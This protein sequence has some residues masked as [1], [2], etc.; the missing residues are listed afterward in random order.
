MDREKF[1]QLFN[2]VKNKSVSLQS[3][4]DTESDES[5]TLTDAIKNADSKVVGEGASKQCSYFGDKQQFAMLKYKKTVVKKAQGQFEKTDIIMFNDWLISKGINTPKL[6][7]MF[8]A[9]EHYHEI[10]ER[11]KG[12]D[13][14]LAGH[15]RIYKKAMGYDPIRKRMEELSPSDIKNPEKTKSVLNLTE[16]E[17]SVI[18]DFL[19]DYTIKNQQLML[20]Y[21]DSEYENLLRQYRFLHNIG[22]RA[23]DTNPGN[24][25]VT[26]NG[27]EII[28]LDIEKNLE[29]ILIELSVS[30]G[31]KYTIPQLIKRLDAEPYVY[32]YTYDNSP[33]RSFRDSLAVDYLD[34]FLAGSWHC[35]LM[36]EN[37]AQEVRNNVGLI[38][39][40]AV[41]AMSKSSML[42]ERNWQGGNYLIMEAIGNNQ[43]LYEQIMRSQIELKKRK[44][45]S[46]DKGLIR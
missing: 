1:E 7:T 23:L 26:K 14:Y 32:M 15:N 12:E 2:S 28:D 27:F 17:K 29:R 38:L 44:T 13:I 22:F 36:T 40:K 45:I 19:Y 31:K 16:E 43:P 39:E 11:V 30:E 46:D 10:Y 6:Y 5:K 42:L 34:P 3:L 41:N 33:I 20:S 8:F 25:M 37:Q 24:L 18:G 9:D 4:S 21:P 35:N